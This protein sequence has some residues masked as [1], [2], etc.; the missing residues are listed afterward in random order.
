MAGKRESRRLLGDLI[1]TEQDVRQ[2][3]QFPDACLVS[4]WHIDLHI[5]DPKNEAAF[6]EG[7]FRSLGKPAVPAGV[8]R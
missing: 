6:P 1:L 7:A 4:P 2:Q 8:T 5:A 3:R